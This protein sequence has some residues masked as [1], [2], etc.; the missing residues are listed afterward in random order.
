M[1]KT[2]TMSSFCL[3]RVIRASVRLKFGEDTADFSLGSPLL[4]PLFID[5]FLG[6]SEPSVLKYRLDYI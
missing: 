3:H 1:D 2:Y 4:G 6:L 5:D